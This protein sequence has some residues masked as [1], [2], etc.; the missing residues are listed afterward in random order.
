MGV[1]PTILKPLQFS[2]LLDR[3]TNLLVA[4]TS[5]QNGIMASRV[6]H[7]TSVWQNYPKLVNGA[8]PTAH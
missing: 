8:S 1:I 6:V 7:H 3:E 5:L 2:I 4:Y